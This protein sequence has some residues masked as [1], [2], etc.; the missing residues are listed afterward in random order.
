MKHH[1]CADDCLE[2]VGCLQVSHA[3][4]GCPC[5]ASEPSQPTITEISSKNSSWERKLDES[6]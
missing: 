4:L 1:V 3:V 6:K 2:T 5:N